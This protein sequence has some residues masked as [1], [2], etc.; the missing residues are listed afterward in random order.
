MPDNTLST[1]EKIRIKVRRLTKS[2][3]NAQITDDTINDYI[4][5]FVLYDF[6]EHL[7]TFSLRR[8]YTFFTQPNVDTYELNDLAD[9]F[10]NTC[11]NIYGNFYVAGQ[12]TIYSQN[13][14]EFYNLYP[15]VESI[16]SIATGDSVTDDFT[17]TLSGVPILRGHVSFT[18]IA[19][20]NVGMA[21]YDVPN[22]PNDGE[23][24]FAGDIGAVSTI[25][26]TTGEYDITF[27]SP[28]DTDKSVDSQTVIYAAGM[29]SAVL[30]YGN[31]I[32]L[33]PVPDKPYAVNFEYDIR[34]TELLTDASQPLLSQWWQYIAYGAAK[35]VFEDRMDMESV[36]MIMP[37]FKKQEA[38]V[39]RRT[40]NQ[41]SQERTA[42]IYSGTNG[43][44]SGFFNEGGY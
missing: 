28:P 14:E 33:R 38:L 3:S 6:P 22:D 30:F 21:M 17:G 25:N 19:D 5:T 7:R 4:N 18:S 40:V 43:N 29:P 42:T 8:T 15:K 27:S 35:K 2:P 34:P 44:V 39:N 36:Q 24:T 10:L 32:I 41:Q 26:Y 16:K 13:R 1:L 9:N 31:S 12:K 20:N 37:E 11:I 23:G